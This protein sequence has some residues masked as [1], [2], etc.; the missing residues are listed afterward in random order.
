MRKAEKRF[1]DKVVCGNEND[2]WLWQGCV[3]RGGYGQMRFNGKHIYAHRFSF[4]LTY[5]RMPELDILHSCDNPRCVNPHH[6]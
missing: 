4:F 1:W 2:C 6:I 5:G 3:V